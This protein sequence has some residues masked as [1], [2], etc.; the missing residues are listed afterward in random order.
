MCPQMCP[1]FATSER[2]GIFSDYAQL[3]EALFPFI[4]DKILSFRR[5]GMAASAKGFKELDKFIAYNHL[6]SPRH[7]K[8]DH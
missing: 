8:N 6:F 1:W 3:Q 4:S 2:Q 5:E 7:L